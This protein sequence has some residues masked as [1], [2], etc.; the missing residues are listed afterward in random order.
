MRIIKTLAKDIRE[1]LHDAEK[2]AKAALETKAEHPGLAETFSRLAD[3]EVG[4]A[5]RLHGE[6]VKM[7]DKASRE[8]NVP[9]IMKEIWAFEHE[10][11][12]E[13]MAE[14]KRLIEMYKT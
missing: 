11:I 13:D 2:Y 12:V 10:I 1:E 5:M 4:H 3:E 9:P 7:I 14:V 8:T 6:V